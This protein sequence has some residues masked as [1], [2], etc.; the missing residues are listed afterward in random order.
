MNPSAQQA[1]VF[2]VQEHASQVALDMQDYIPVNPTGYKAIDDLIGGIAPGEQCIIA[3]RPSMG[4][5]SLAIGISVNVAKSGRVVVYFTMESSPEKLT[6]RII[7][8]EAK[9]NRRQVERQLATQDEIDRLHAAS[10]EIEDGCPIRIVTAAKTIAQ[11]RSHIRSIKR[12]CDVALVVVDHIGRM[13]TGNR[14]ESLY[15][16][17]TKL[18]SGLNHMC[19]EE[20]VPLIVIS[21]MNRLSETATDHRPRLSQLRDSGALEQDADIVLLLYREDYYHQ[22]DADWKDTNICECTIA[23]ARDNPTGVVKLTWMSEFTRMENYATDE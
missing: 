23:K 14:N 19:K 22:G 9:V 11:Q 6:G 4:K 5:T 1:Q 12:T 20:Q 3:G 8:S 7:C 2:D 15:Q 10:M 13:T 21:Q 16:S 17:T 18:S